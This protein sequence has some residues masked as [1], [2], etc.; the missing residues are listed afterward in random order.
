MSEKIRVLL[1]GHG[2]REAALAASI[3]KRDVDIFA[4]GR[5]KNPLIQQ[6]SKSFQV[7]NH[8]LPE[9]LVSQATRTN[10]DLIMIGPEEPIAK[11]AADL[12]ASSGFWVCAP[13]AKASRLEWDKI[14]MRNFLSV[15]C[16]SLNIP[17]VIV[18]NTTEVHNFFENPPWPVAVKP[19]GLTGGKGVKV[20][21]VHLASRAETEAFTNECLATTGQPVLLEQRIA[22][23]EFTLHC[24]TDGKHTAFFKATYDYSYRF[25]ND[26]G[27]QTGGMGSYCAPTGWLPFMTEQE[28]S[29]SCEAMLNVLFA[30]KQENIEYCGV[31]QGQFFLSKAGLKICEFACRF[32]DPEVINLLDTTSLS[33]LDIM[34]EIRDGT[35]SEGRLPTSSN[36]SVA[37]MCCAAWISNRII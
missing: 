8:Y 14:F 13:N 19:C 21:G 15:H 20:E 24:V 27:P 2:C 9:I 34:E 16:P 6:C 1:I 32:G 30:L 12:L 29:A 4:I 26:T 11:G 28:Y 3:A 23:V 22:G 7:V 33:W 35:L 17:F 18:K 37:P 25:K 10:P 36:S 31:L 5:F